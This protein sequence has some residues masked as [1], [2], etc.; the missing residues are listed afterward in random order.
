MIKDALKSLA[1]NFLI[2]LRL[3]PAAAAIDTA[4][5]KKMFGSGTT[6]LLISNE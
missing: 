5:H 3:K 1:K 6:T 2:P 4:V